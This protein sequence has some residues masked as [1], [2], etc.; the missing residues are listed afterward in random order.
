MGVTVGVIRG[1]LGA[2]GTPN[3]SKAVQLMLM[4]LAWHPLI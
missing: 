2:P 3:L 1:I 4:M